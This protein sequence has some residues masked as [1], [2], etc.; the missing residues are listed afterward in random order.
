VTP[1][2]TIQSLGVPPDLHAERIV[3][4]MLAWAHD[5]RARLNERAQGV[6]NVDQMGSPTGQWR[7]CERLRKAAGK[8]LL[9]VRL[10]RAK[11][12]KGMILTTDWSI[13]DP[14]AQ[15][16][17]EDD[18]RMP[19]TAWLA[20][21]VN[22]ITAVNHRFDCNSATV[23]LLTHH[24][25]VR[26]C[27]RCG[28]RDV[29]GLLGALQALWREVFALME[30]HPDQGWLK[31]PGGIWRVPV[32]NVVAIIEPDQSGEPRLVVKTVLENAP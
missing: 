31:P 27:Q 30:S 2:P 19:E 10:F 25:C 20:A 16:L 4:E 15:T 3:R 26:L 22:T 18:R 32:G 29:D 8:S 1:A 28:V 5:E 13:W 21:V 12:G 6:I 9:D 11:R 14:S 7:T 23:L 24:A 17:V